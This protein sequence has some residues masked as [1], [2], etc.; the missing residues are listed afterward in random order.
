MHYIITE[1]MHFLWFVYVMSKYKRMN[2]IWECCMA[3]NIAVEV[4][5]FSGW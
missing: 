4:R 5:K 1:I 2:P 3:R